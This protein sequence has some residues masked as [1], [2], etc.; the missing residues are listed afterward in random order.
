[1]RTAWAAVLLSAAALAALGVAPACSSTAKTAFPF[2]G[3]FCSNVSA[4]CWQCVESNCAQD[5]TC[6]TS[7]CGD[8]WSCLC[9]CA[10]SDAACIAAC[11][12]KLTDACTE[13]RKHV[14]ACETTHCLGGTQEGPSDQC[15]GVSLSG[16]LVGQICGGGAPPTCVGSLGGAGIGFCY[17]PALLDG[18]A[19][20]TCASA[21][22]NVGYTE[23]PCVSCL[24]ADLATCRAQALQACLDGGGDI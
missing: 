19:G 9:A 24:P 6:I 11:Q 1:M 23:F 18:D 21:T 7:T 14:G 22:Y 15:P 8:F 4:T 13:C 3:P 10:A 16:P 20:F 2:N 5:V 12:P 17:Y